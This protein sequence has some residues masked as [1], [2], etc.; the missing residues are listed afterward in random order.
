MAPADMGWLET[1]KF[2]RWDGKAGKIRVAR[3]G[4]KRW[5]LLL[6]VT[7]VVVLGYDA[8]CLW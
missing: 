7:G 6:A 5:W 8:T 4:G 2:Q 3:P 1:S